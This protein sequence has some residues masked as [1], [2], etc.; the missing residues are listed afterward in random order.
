MSTIES[1]VP[2]MQQA[3]AVLLREADQ[4][5]NNKAKAKAHAKTAPRFDRRTFLAYAG[6]TAAA[7]ALVVF[8]RQ[9]EAGPFSLAV[10][11]VF[12]KSWDVIVVGA[13]GAG[14]AAAVSAAEKGAKVLLVEKMGAV[15][16][17]TLLAS[18]L[19]NAADPV[20]QKP[21]G[22]EDSTD[23]HFEQTLES[24]GGRSDP[25]VIRRFVDEALPTL[26]WLESLGMVFLPGVVTTWGAEWPRGH[27]PLLPR[28]Q[29]YIRLL[30]GKLLELGGEIRFNTTLKAIVRSPDNLESFDRSEDA[31]DVENVNP[32]GS[33]PR[34][35]VTGIVVTHSGKEKGEVEEVLSARCGVVL[36]AGGYAQNREMLRRY[37][38][39][40]ADFST[41]NAPGSTGEAIFAAERAGAR[42][43][44]LDCVQTVPGAPKGRRFQVR[45]DLDSGRFILVDGSGRR[46]IDEDASRDQLSAA[47]IGCEG[48]RAYSI[49]DNATVDFYDLISKKDIYRGLLTGDALRAPTLEA[50]AERIQL[51]AEA[52]KQSVASFNDDVSNKRGKCGRILCAPISKPPF[53]ASRIVLTVHSTMGGVAIDPNGAVLDRAGNPIPGLFAAGEIVGNLHGRNRIGGN[54]I[55]AAITMGRIAGQSAADSFASSAR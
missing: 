13:G 41:D 49:T 7:G 32:P 8:Q 18:G 5:T 15:G 53:W 31:D 20:R 36:A 4:E 6:M 26:H 14:L 29:G 46:F 11:R 25:K 23:W 17:N 52:L 3:K 42:I 44:N 54:G 51:P 24:A 45:L 38:P 47:I 28:G 2:P 30:A 48:G 55:G 35:R 33:R 22:I 19:F 40:Y 37:A 10:D 39:Q 50:L 12:N 43:V 34:G 9:A 21:L 27:K 16:G 1:K